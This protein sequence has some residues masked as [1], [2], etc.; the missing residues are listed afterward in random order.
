MRYP[1]A[2]STCEW[3]FTMIISIHCSPIISCLKCQL[4]CE[5]ARTP[6]KR[7]CSLKDLSVILLEYK[8]THICT[9]STTSNLMVS[10][11]STFSEYLSLGWYLAGHDVTFRYWHQNGCLHFSSFLEQSFVNFYSF[12]TYDLKIFL[13]E[14]HLF[15]GLPRGNIKTYNVLT[16]YLLENIDFDKD[17]LFED[18]LIILS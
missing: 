17:F 4:V 11:L 1:H 2:V 14:F 9:S 7:C 16:G 15:P 6:I 5:L 12:R 8:N 13:D 10:T 18:I 3:S